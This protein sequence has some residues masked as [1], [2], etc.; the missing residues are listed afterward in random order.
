MKTITFILLSVTILAVLSLNALAA[1]TRCDIYF[2]ETGG[3]G[4]ER[5][6][7]HNLTVASV[8]NECNWRGNTSSL[9]FYCND[10]AVPFEL[11][12]SNETVRFILTNL[13]A[14]HTN[15]KPCYYTF[16][17]T[18]GISSANVS[19]I[20]VWFDGGDSKGS[21][22]DCP[23]GTTSS[24]WAYSGEKSC[25]LTALQN[26]NTGINYKTFC[27]TSNAASGS[28]YND[29]QGDVNDN[30]RFFADTTDNI[31]C[32][33][34]DNVWC[35]S[36]GV[37]LSQ[38]PFNLNTP[39]IICFNTTSAT[40]RTGEYHKNGTQ[41]NNTASG[42]AHTSLTNYKVQGNGP[43]TKYF[44]EVFISN[45]YHFLM[46]P[47]HLKI[48]VVLAPPSGPDVP[49]AITFYNMTSSGGCGAWNTNKSA[50]C[51][52]EDTTPTV[53]AT[54]NE[55]AYCRIGVSDVNYTAMGDLRNCTGG[56]TVSHICSLTDS[57]AI[58][59]LEAN[60]YISCKDTAGNENITSTSGALK[61]NIT[62]ANESIG[63]AQIE[64]GIN[65]SLI[66]GANILSSQ[67][68]YIRTLT[69]S[70]TLGRFDKVAISGSQRWAFNY[71]SLNETTSQ[72]TNMVNIT[73]SFYV[74]EIANRTSTNISRTISAFIN[75]TKQ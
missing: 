59:S 19:I 7:V 45:T 39:E 8:P 72:F 36:S 50:P 23:L 57:D 17:D 73:P 11:N 14:S 33:A 26:W 53:N 44:D 65:S 67:Q 58:T 32:T 38:T 54:I 31:G 13:S 48:G 28:N 64:S 12:A 70:Q 6:L 46:Y 2:N 43:Y 27:Y 75:A 4:S 18:A 9:R 20:Q 15:S 66:S 56:N 16:N 47:N 3:F 22:G 74:L 60:I 69:N 34:A 71:I 21:S 68:V 5:E 62:P 63:D 55:A 61:M 51:T 30:F 35:N 29:Y 37:A 49:P 10:E 1:Q 41:F 40:D 24:A 25:I 42:A 52:T